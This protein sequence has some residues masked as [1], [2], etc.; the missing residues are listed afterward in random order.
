M[1]EINDI[2]ICSVREYNKADGGNMCMLA[3]PNW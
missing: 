3:T 2:Y 1:L